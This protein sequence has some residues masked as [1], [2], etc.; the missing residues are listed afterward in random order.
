MKPATN[1]LTLEKC[2]DRQKINK[3]AWPGKDDQ[4]CSAPEIACAEE[5]E[6]N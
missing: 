4:R 3:F 2:R 5:R 1:C 6:R